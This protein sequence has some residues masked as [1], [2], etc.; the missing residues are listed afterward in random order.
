MDWR[1]KIQSIVDDVEL[2][3]QDSDNKNLVRNAITLIRRRKRET[4]SV[5]GSST[6]FDYDFRRETDDFEYD[7]EGKNTTNIETKSKLVSL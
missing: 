2:E 4:E 6:E 5:T 7:D 1:K 3:S